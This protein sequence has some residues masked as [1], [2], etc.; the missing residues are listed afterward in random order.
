MKIYSQANIIQFKSRHIDDENIIGYDDETSQNTR[1]ILREWHETYYMPYQSIYEK[2]H[3]LTDYQLGQLIKPLTNKPKVVDYN[4][5]LSLPIYNVKPVDSKQNCFRGATLVNHSD[6]LPTLKKCGIERVIDLVGYT[7]YEHEAKNIGLEYYTPRFGKYITGLWSETAFQSESE[8]IREELIYLPFKE[9]NDV[10]IID[11]KKK[12]YKEESKESIDNFIDL[13]QVLQK[14]HYYIGCEYGTDRTSAYLLLNDVFNP[15]ATPNPNLKLKDY[16]A[17]FEI[18][19]MHEL[20]KKLT[21]EHKEKLG[22]TKEF[23]KKVLA[24]LTDE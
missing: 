13:I 1:N 23:D 8:F 9:R 19:Y 24:K 14:G 15:K 17:N 5:I 20:Y 16:A 4:T 11:E 12:M 6:C 7:K 21:P 10:K 3:R 2:E 18:D 22:W